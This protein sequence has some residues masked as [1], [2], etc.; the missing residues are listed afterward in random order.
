VCIEDS[1]TGLQAARKAGMRVVVTYTDATKTQVG[2]IVVVM[3][4]YYKHDIVCQ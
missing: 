3:R 4:L 1:T 2:A